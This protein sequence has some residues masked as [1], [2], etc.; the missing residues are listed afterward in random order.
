MT[1]L[2]TSNEVLNAIKGTPSSENFWEAN[3]VSIDSRTIMPGNIFIAIDGEKFDGHSYIDEAF[4]KGAIAA[5]VSKKIKN[6]ANKNYIFV[7]NTLLSLEDLAKYS[8]SRTKAKIIAITGSVGKTTTKEIL[9]T[10]LKNQFLVY[11]SQGNLNNQIGVPLS[12]ARIPAQTDFA[13]LELGMNNSGEI[14]ELTKIAKP[15]YALITAIEAAHLEFFSSIDGIAEAKAEIFEGVE[16]KG[17]AILNRDNNFFN[18]LS[19]KAKEHN[20]KVISFGANEKADVKLLSYVLHDECSC[21]KSDINGQNMVLKI[22][23]PGLHVIN[24]CLSVLAVVHAIGGDLS[25]ASISFSELKLPTGRGNRKMFTTEDGEIELIDESYNASP[26]SMKAALQLLGQS[27]L[28]NNGRRIAVLGDML[29]LG[30]K[31]LSFHEGLSKF[32]EKACVDMVFC[33]GQYMKSLYKVLPEGIYK[34]WKSESYELTSSIKSKLRAGDVVMVKGSFGSKMSVIVRDL[35][36][37]YK[38]KMNIDRY[39]N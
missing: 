7:K 19:K 1:P 39:I 12:L 6:F 16:N 3:G 27:N 23:S 38:K 18:K 14:R 9:Y 26:A 31:S 15:N 35:D 28:K 37:S 20:L 10:A 36:E 29:E 8:R 21:V 22:G 34:E 30:V 17:I 13:I 4:Q 24:N 5:V 11:A 25:L 32:I 33:S 2:W